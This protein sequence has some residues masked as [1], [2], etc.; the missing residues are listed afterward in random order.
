MGY[1]GILAD[2]WSSCCEKLLGEEG[3]MV[4]DLSPDSIAAVLAGDSQVG[5]LLN[6]GPSKRRRIR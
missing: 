2:C 4:C 5:F 3:D 1:A 6:G